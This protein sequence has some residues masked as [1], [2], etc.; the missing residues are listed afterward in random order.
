MNNELSELLDNFLAQKKI[1]RFEGP[2]GRENLITIV[3]A[4]GYRS[5][6]RYD[7]DQG[8]ALEAFL[9]DNPGAIEAIV[10]WIKKQGSQEWIQMLTEQGCE[11]TNEDGDEED[12]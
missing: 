12:S 5:W 7:T 11:A 4:L 8:R 1:Y 2:Q 3:R 6:N 10:E 9:E